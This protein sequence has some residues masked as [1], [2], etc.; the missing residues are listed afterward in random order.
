MVGVLLVIGLSVVSMSSAVAAETYDL[1]ILEGRVMDP[2]TR[3]DAVRNVGVKDGKI[4]VITGDKIQGNE[5]INAKDHAVTA[6]NTRL[7]GY[8][9]WR[10]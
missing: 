10:S 4:A 2:E 9:G 1:V 5:T 3:L 8:G 7:S 6:D